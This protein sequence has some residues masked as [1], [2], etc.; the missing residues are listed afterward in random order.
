MLIS[1]N[2]SNNKSEYLQFNVKVFV[3]LKKSIT[4]KNNL[5]RLPYS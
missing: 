3:T 5:F 1:K 4:L 2:Y